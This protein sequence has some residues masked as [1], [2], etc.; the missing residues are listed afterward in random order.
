MNEAW[1][2]MMAK[3][4][5]DSSQL[6]SAIFYQEKQIFNFKHHK[7]AMLAA[8]VV[9]FELYDFMRS[10]YIFDTIENLLD[11]NAH[12]YETNKQI[13]QIIHLNTS[14]IQQQ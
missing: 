4:L 11:I 6:A 9:L 2:I 5:R 1:A 14:K 3:T 12:Y 8:I 13:I 10:Q 7:V